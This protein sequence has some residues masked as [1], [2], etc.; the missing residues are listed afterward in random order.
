MWQRAK[1]H[2]DQGV[3]L[4]R[5]IKSMLIVTQEDESTN[6]QRTKLVKTDKNWIKPWPHQWMRLHPMK[7]KFALLPQMEVSFMFVIFSSVS[8]TFSKKIFSN[9]LLMPCWNF[10]GHDYELQNY[11]FCPYIIPWWMVHPLLLISWDSKAKQII[12]S[13]L[14][15]SDWGAKTLVNNVK[16][17]ISWAWVI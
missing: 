15:H 17:G 5:L 2:G 9:E 6:K 3:M 12:V 7:L 16:S 10:L 11:T 13:V 1:G 14:L 8:D 4:W